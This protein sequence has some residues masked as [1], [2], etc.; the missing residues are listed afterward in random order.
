MIKHLGV[1]GMCLFLGGCASMYPIGYTYCKGDLHY[2]KGV[3][4]ENS[5]KKGLIIDDNGVIK[6][7]PY[8]K[9]YTIITNTKVKHENL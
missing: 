9:C 4:L 2:I 8:D 1:I 5:P 3:I 7:L 6:K